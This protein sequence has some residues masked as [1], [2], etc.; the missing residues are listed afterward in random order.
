[1]DDA[2][3]KYL[4]SKA[5]L[6]PSIMPINKLVGFEKSEKNSLDST[7]TETDLP[8]DIDLLSID[9]DSFDLAVWEC[10]KETPKVV[11]I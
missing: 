6:F 9:I 11:V 3:Y 7:P 10:I 8:E 5:E 2:S 1:M 4:L